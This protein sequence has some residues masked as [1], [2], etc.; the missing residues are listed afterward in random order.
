MKPLIFCD[1]D[2][3]ICCL[4]WDDDE[5]IWGYGDTPSEAYDNWKAQV[6]ITA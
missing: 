5:A 1:G 2:G 3:W 6:G 4:D